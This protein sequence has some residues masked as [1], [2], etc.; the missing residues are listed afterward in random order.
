[1]EE[2]EMKKLK[3][4]ERAEHRIDATNCTKYIVHL[5]VYDLL[6]PLIDEAE[7]KARQGRKEKVLRN[8]KMLK[9]AKNW[10][11]ADD[12]SWLNWRTKVTQ[13]EVPECV[14]IMWEVTGTGPPTSEWE[15]L[16]DESNYP[17][18]YNSASGESSY[19]VPE[20]NASGYEEEY[21]EEGY[22]GEQPAADGAYYD[23]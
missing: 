8:K 12:G 2:M 23:Y 20:N 13:W 11:E 6:D 15:L 10:E 19:E 9:Q 22:A 7:E 14:Q 21:Y 4:E 17:Y 5:M 1:M 18:Y 16:Y 3:R